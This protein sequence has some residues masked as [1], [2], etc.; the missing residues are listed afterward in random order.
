MSADIGAEPLV[1]VPAGDQIPTQARRSALADGSAGQWAQFSARILQRAGAPRTPLVERLRLLSLFADEIDETFMVD[2]GGPDPFVAHAL[3]AQRD[4]IIDGVR[5][6]LAAAGITV[7]RWNHLSRGEQK[8]LRK[9]LLDRIG[10]VLTPLAVDPAHPFPRVSGLS[11]NLAVRLR[12]RDTGEECFACV[13]IPPLLPRFVSLG[14]LRFA[15][16]EEIVSAHLP[17]L[18]PGMDVL[19]R[20]CFRVTRSQ[21]L[22]GNERDRTDLL[23]DLE[24][25][26]IRRRF[27]APVRLE[28]DEGVSGNLLELLA[29]Q[30]GLR[31]DATYFVTNPLAMGAGLWTIPNV[32]PQH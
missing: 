27:G 30:L 10:P 26:A 22:D 32:F 14:D 25:K 21:Q 15:R 7:L 18:F 28:V 11:L 20:R 4:T 16:L 19:E 1:R 9:L 6:D 31:P 13:E 3:V 2:G 24:R 8:R 23:V 12:D 17:E 29:R 5:A